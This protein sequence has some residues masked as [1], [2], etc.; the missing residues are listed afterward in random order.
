MEPFYSTLKTGLVQRYVW[1]TRAKARLAIFDYVEVFYNRQQLHSTLGYVS[2]AEYE[3]CLAR[4][5][6]HA[7]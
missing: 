2:P 5:A 7:A 6:A 1:P 3:G 4:A